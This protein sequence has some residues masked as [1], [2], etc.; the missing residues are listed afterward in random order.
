[1]IVAYYVTG[2]VWPRNPRCR[3]GPSPR[4][5]GSRVVVCSGAPQFIFEMV[6]P[7]ESKSLLSFHRVVVDYGAIQKDALTVDCAASLIGYSKL[8]TST[9]VKEESAFIRKQ[10]VHVVVADMPP[11]A[12]AAARAA[13]VPCAVVTNF[14]WDFIYAEFA[15]HRRLRG[16]ARRN[17]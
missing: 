2:R 14:T 9:I 1:M 10:G 12:C 17:R 11:L 15:S 16:N 13:G 7:E 6:I 5:S 3:G 8:D 4:S